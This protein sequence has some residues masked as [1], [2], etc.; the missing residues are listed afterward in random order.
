MVERIFTILNL[1]NSKKR[2]KISY[3]LEIVGV[4]PETKGLTSAMLRRKITDV[5]DEMLN[6]FDDP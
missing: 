5:K 6:I 3:M 1:N 4:Y 2:K